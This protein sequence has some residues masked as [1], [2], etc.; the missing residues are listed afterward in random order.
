[1]IWQRKAARVSLWLMGKIQEKP[2]GEFC[3]NDN[4]L[5]EFYSHEVL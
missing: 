1:M 5:V 4:V 2:S 3:N